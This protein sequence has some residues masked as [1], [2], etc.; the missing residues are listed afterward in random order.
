[1]TAAELAHAAAAARLPR[2]DVAYESVPE[3]EAL[4]TRANAVFRGWVER[5][6]TRVQDAIQNC[7]RRAGVH[8]SA[9]EHELVELELGG[10]RPRVTRRSRCAATSRRGS[11]GC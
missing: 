10:A 3:E 7:T 6:R 9:Y 11:T 8:L 5:V 4:A 2:T 1:D